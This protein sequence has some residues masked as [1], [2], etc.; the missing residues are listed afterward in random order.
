LPEDAVRWEANCAKNKRQQARRWLRSA[1]RAVTRA[2]GQKL[3]LSPNP[4]EMTMRRMKT[5]KMLEIMSRVE[6]ENSATLASAR[7]DA[8]GFIRKIALLEDELVMEH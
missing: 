1:I 2:R 8:D 6:E 3:P 5:R 4:R 7:E